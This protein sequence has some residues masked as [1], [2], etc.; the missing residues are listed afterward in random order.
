MANNNEW[1]ESIVY[2]EAHQEEVMELAAR[3][4]VDGV[5]ETVKETLDDVGIGLRGVPDG[6]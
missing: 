4:Y 3:I 1:A 5:V 2:L 6:D